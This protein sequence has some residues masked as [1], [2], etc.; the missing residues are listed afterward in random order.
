MTVKEKMGG[1]Y[2]HPTAFTVALEQ[3][4]LMAGSGDS[5]DRGGGGGGGGG[6]GDAKS[7]NGIFDDSDDTP[8][9]NDDKWTK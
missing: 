9:D 6:G 2:V 3:S 7:F 5:E 8:L 4:P 1:V